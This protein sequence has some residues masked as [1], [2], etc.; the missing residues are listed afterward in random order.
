MLRAAAAEFVE[1]VAD[2]DYF[3]SYELVTQVAAGGPWFA[4]NLRDV[5]PDGVARV[6][7]I[8]LRAHGLLDAEAPEEAVEP[9]ELEDDEAAD[10]VCDELLLQAFA[11]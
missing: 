7:S 6:M 1:D 10:L 9:N 5:T 4:P 11:R 2:A 3:P 8:F